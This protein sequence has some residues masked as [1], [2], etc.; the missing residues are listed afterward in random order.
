MENLKSYLYIVPI[1]LLLVWSCDNP[2][3]TTSSGEDEIAFK[4]GANAKPGTLDEE[5]GNNLS[6]PVIWSDGEEAMLSIRGTFGAPEFNGSF[7]TLEGIEGEIYEQQHPANE[8]QAQSDTNTTD[9]TIAV[10]T[11]DW[12]DNL[13][14]RSWPVG[15][16][17]RVET[18]L[19]KEGVSMLAFNMFNGTPDVKGP[20]EVWGTNTTTYTSN[21]ATIYSGSARLVIQKLTQ[22]R[23]V[24]QN[25]PSLL[26][27]N[28]TQWVD[29]ENGNGEVS[30]PLFN[31][32]VWNSTEGPG[33]Y[34]AEINVQG[35]VLYGFNWI[36]RDKS[37]Y[38]S[39]DYRI[40]YVLD[41]LNSGFENTV[42]DGS[43]TIK[44]R[45]EGEIEIA[46]EPE[47]EGGITYIDPAND[48]TYID[49]RLSSEKGN[50][51]GGKGIGKGGKGGGE[52]HGH[53][54]NGG[55]GNN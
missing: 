23:E 17:I 9:E 13:E 41:H 39:G 36:T 26:E 37:L 49:V 25:T 2:A 11:V 18:V 52:G 29:G 46:E 51:G 47:L 15:A 54:N 14:A 44:A 34:S 5:T 4:Y 38:E 42:F 7:F 31:G 40:T 35:K 19:Y 1:L 43:T 32:G 28:G 21:E 30:D 24:Y 8:W 45:E 20:T 48:I 27:W 50:K 6:F 22:D 55:R 53:D 10:S 12:G 33:G 3:N 16:Q